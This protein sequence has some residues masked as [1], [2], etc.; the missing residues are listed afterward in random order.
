V[1]NNIK[2]YEIRGKKFV[3]ENKKIVMTVKE[4][5]ALLNVGQNTMYEITARRDFKALIQIGR[6]KLIHRRKLEEWLEEQTK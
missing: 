5:A 3:E 6:K 1:S 4:A 2:K